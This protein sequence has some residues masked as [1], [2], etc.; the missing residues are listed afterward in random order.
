MNKDWKK[1]EKL[2]NQ[3]K[4]NAWKEEYSEEE[5]SVMKVHKEEKAVKG[6]QQCKGGRVVKAR[7]FQLES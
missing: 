6:W 3:L 5:E 7:G 4:K 1:V 2:N